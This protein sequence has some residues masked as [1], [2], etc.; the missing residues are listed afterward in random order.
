MDSNLLQTRPPCRDIFKLLSPGQ[1]N[2]QVDAIFGLEFNLRFVCPPTCVALH[3]L[4]TTCV[5]CVDFGRA[6]IWTQVD[7]SFY[8]FFGHPAQVDTSWAQVKRINHELYARN[9]HGF[10]RLASRLANSFGQGFKDL[11]QKFIFIVCWTE[12]CLHVIQVGCRICQL[13]FYTRFL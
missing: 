12:T 11:P 10:M 4:A 6:Q 8:R 3:R 9:V 1:T 7:A 13:N 5:D 2:S